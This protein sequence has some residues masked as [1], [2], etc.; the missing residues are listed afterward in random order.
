VQIYLASLSVGKA[1]LDAGKLKGLAVTATARLKGLP[2]VP[3]TKEAG[4]P[5]FAV[6]N[7]WGLAAAAH[8]RNSGSAC[9]R[10]RS[11]TRS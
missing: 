4:A 5:E 9:A 8:R 3:T 10:S 6:S 7:W 11:F 2:D 1:Q